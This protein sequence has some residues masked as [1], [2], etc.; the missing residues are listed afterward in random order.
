MRCYSYRSLSEYEFCFSLLN[1]KKSLFYMSYCLVWF[2]FQSSILLRFTFFFIRVV[3]CCVL[4]FWYTWMIQRTTRAHVLAC[5]CD[6]YTQTQTMD[7]SNGMQTTIAPLQTAQF[8]CSVYQ[9]RE[10][11]V[12][13]GHWSMSI[14]YRWSICHG[15]FNKCYSKFGT[16]ISSCQ[17]CYKYIW[18]D[19]QRLNF[20]G[21]KMANQMIEWND[22]NQI[23]EKTVKF[24][25]IHSCVMYF[26]LESRNSSWKSNIDGI[27]ISSQDQDEWPTDRQNTCRMSFWIS[28]SLRLNGALFSYFF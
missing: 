5:P 12:Y 20:T 8:A 6:S 18:I 9:Y 19:T 4:Y 11:H 3:E 22:I 13:N 15:I 28:W 23:F 17:C 1:H 10:M 2:D 16:F 14:L 26:P 24:K 7:K 27:Y 21:F 25:S